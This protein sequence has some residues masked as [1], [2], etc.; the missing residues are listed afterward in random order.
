MS[1]QLYAITGR[2]YTPNIGQEVRAQAASLP[3]LYQLR[4]ER[5]ARERG[6]GIQ[7]RGL[8]L[9]SADLDFQRQALSRQEDL[10]RD[11]MRAQE[12]QNRQS[13]ILGMAGLGINYGLGS[14]ANR[15]ILADSGQAVGGD[16]AGKAV[17]SGGGINSG[18]LMDSRMLDSVN[19][20]SSGFVQPQRTA[21]ESV[22]NFARNYGGALAGGIGGALMGDN[23]RERVLYGLGGAAIGDLVSGGS[24]L[25]N[26]VGSALNLG[27]GITRLF[28][29]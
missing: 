3:N 23:N 8:D 21:M 11:Q 22:G 28:G 25:R 24:L 18:S 2:R 7:E 4:D 26:V 15:A 20:T 27:S 5:D 29:F 1:N 12:Q 14:R 16:V 19:P 10:A 6:L 17:A 9:Q 13:N